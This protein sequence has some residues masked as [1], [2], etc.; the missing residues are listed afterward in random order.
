MA[1]TGSGQLSLG[2]IAG[3]FG[4]SAPHAL[5]EYYDGGLGPSEAPSSGQI[6]ISDFHGTQA[7]YD[8][9]D[10]TN[11]MATGRDP[12]NTYVVGDTFT[13]SSTGLYTFDNG[14]LDQVDI[15]IRGGRGGGGWGR[16]TYR[17]AAGTWVTGDFAY[18]SGDNGGRVQCRMDIGSLSNRTMEIRVGTNGANA[19]NTSTFTDGFS[20]QSEAGG[21][22]G[23]GTGHAGG[24]GGGGRS[25][26]SYDT[27][28][29]NELVCAG[30]G[31]GGR[32]NNMGH[33]SGRENGSAGCDTYSANLET[34]VAAAGGGGGYYGGASACGS[35]TTAHGSSIIMGGSGSG[36]NYI[37][38]SYD[39]STAQDSSYG[40][41]GGYTG[42]FKMTVVS[43]T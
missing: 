40:R 39:V 6:K 17:G 35:G 9:A 14:N 42:Y 12:A 11:T 25:Y 28:D 5:S 10:F 18:Y 33:N 36:T 43:I 29:T 1:L 38:G 27:T 2:D 3:E 41:S 37:N 21:T 22:D 13:L 20:A 26:W 7:G 23:G 8:P 31:G 19:A 24:G 32:G 15:D 30:G 16:N 34:D 4:G